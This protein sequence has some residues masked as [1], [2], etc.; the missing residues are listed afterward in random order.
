LSS[1]LRE[2]VEHLTSFERGACS[3]GEKRAA[4]WIAERLR[5]AGCEVEVEEEQSFA[6]YAP[7]LGALGVVAALMGVVSLRTRARL[8]PA[9]VA[10]AG[11]GLVADDAMNGRRWWR[12]AVMKKRATWNVVARLGDESADRTLVVLAH[13]DAHPTSF[14]FDQ[15]L[16][17]WV[18]R[19]REVTEPGGGF[20]FWWPILAAPLAIALGALTGIRTLTKAGLA[21]QIFGIAAAADLARG[22]IVPGANDNLS[23][24]AGLV[25]LA[26]ALAADPPPGVRVLLVSCGAE[27]TLQGGIYGFVETHADELDPA[28]TAVLNFELLGASRHVLLEGEGPVVIEDYT[29]LEFRDL[30]AAAADRA[31]V[32]MQ[33]GVRLHVSTDSVVPSRAGYPTATLITVDGLGMIPNYHLMS[34][35]P[36]NLDYSGIEGAVAIA[37]E[38]AREVGRG[39]AA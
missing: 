39:N 22:R 12:R 10:A 14:L 23:A 38:V 31:D 29:G 25:G 16:E 37:A 8:L 18:A 33:R 7:A 6:S 36:E 28:T 19:R 21:G 17:R 1:T 24:V 4:E 13:H 35:V 20:P 11:T 9:L 15:G 26:E 2:V 30:V 5:A 32:P 27:E 3:P 34:D